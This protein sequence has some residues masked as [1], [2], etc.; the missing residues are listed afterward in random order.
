MQSILPVPSS[1]SISC[2][3]SSGRDTQAIFDGLKKHPREVDGYLAGAG[4]RKA[5]D[6]LNKKAF[7]NLDSLE[8]ALR[9]TGASRILFVCRDES[10]VVRRLVDFQKKEEVWHVAGA[11]DLLGIP[12]NSVPL[13]AAKLE[14]LRKWHD[15]LMKSDDASSHVYVNLSVDK[16]DRGESVWVGQA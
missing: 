10:G 14:S 8:T 2:G 15:A 4:F 6:P 9:S 16:K 12:E 13:D 5:T 1:T 11:G 7:A 3:E